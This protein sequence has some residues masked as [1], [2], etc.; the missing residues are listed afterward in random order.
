MTTTDIYLKRIWLKIQIISF[1]NEKTILFFLYIS[2]QTCKTNLIE[3]WINFSTSLM[4]GFKRGSTKFKLT[5]WLQWYALLPLVHIMCEKISLQ[6][7]NNNKALQWTLESESILSNK[8]NCESQTKCLIFLFTQILAYLFESN[9]FITFHY[10]IPIKSLSNAIQQFCYLL[11]L[12]RAQASK[13]KTKLFMFSTYSA[14][15]DE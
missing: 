7:S 6:F 9:N 5:T 13:L 4:Q 11:I 3:V 1:S 8:L 12:H 14:R 2:K 15:Q 10:F